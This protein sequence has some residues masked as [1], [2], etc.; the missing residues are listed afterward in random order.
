VSAGVP[1]DLFRDLLGRFA[2]G[3]TVLTARAADGRPFGMTANAVA[4]VSLDPPLVLVCVDRTR[5]IHDVLRAAHRFAL[6]VLAEDQE[7]V[8]RRFAEDSAD[9]FA[10]TPVLE[11]P[12]GLPLVAGA[13]AH[14][15][16]ALRDAVAAGDHTIFI[17]L[18]TGGTAFDRAPLTYFRAGYGGFVRGAPRGPRQSSPPGPLPLTGE[19]ERGGG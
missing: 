13:V 17:G 16:C 18:V 2:T 10:G 8:S 6:S 14:I 1:P 9:R 12:H 7:A 15:L 19:W 4:S 3:V 11:G 5:D